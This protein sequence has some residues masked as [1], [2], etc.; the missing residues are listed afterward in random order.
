MS[1]KEEEQE[2]HQ[3]RL[4][5]GRE[6]RL[7]EI[8][9]CDDQWPSIFEQNPRRI[10]EALGDGALR[11]EHMGSTSVPGLSA[12]AVI[13]ILVVVAN[14]GDEAGYLPALKEAG[15]EL[16]VREPE[17][18]EHRNLR[19]PAR[20][21][22]IHVL[23]PQSREIDRYLSLRSQLRANAGARSAD[24]QVSRTPGKCEWDDMNDYAD[25]KTDTVEAI[26]AKG[27]RAFREEGF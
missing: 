12:T 11:I 6:K 4:I 13:D 17:C 25:A 22:H 14:P 10:R 2:P 19:S 5:G 7:V 21:V 16:R 8:H 3:V 15:Y 1:V 24:E 23:P 27:T 20:D 26:I 18:D 9:D